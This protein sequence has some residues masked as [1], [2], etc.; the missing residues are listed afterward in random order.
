MSRGQI[1]TS[2]VGRNN[3]P[4]G[5][6][7]RGSTLETVLG[8][9]RI[10]RISEQ[11]DRP[12][13]S[14]G[15][16]NGSGGNGSTVATNSLRSGCYSRRAMR[17]SHPIVAVLTILAILGPFAQGAITMVHLF[18]ENGHEQDGHVA[19]LEIAFH[20]HAHESGS[21]A[22]SHSCTT[23]RAAS[24]ERAASMVMDPQSISLT[25]TALPVPVRPV[26]SGVPGSGEPR[27]AGPLPP[28]LLSPIL[29]I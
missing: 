25:T 4:W 28:S 14:S 5:S 22:H 9:L 29:R 20:G 23:P 24:S 1:E 12:V 3:G 16:E 27:S 18:L 2:S 10:I 8:K 11:V 17:K 6:R 19:E 7:V 21:P 15:V 13:C 26:G